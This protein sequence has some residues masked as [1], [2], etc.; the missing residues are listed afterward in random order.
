M[1]NKNVDN[2]GQHGFGI[3]YNIAEDLK[4]P[5]FRILTQL[6]VKNHQDYHNHAQIIADSALKMLDSYLI[7]TQVYI[8]QQQFVIEPVSAHAIIYESGQQLSKLAR[9]HNFEIELDIQRSIGQVMANYHALQS[10]IISVAYSFLYNYNYVHGK[11]KNTLLFSLRSKKQGA[12]IGIF[13]SDNHISA[14]S[15][16]RMRRLRG[17]ARTPL[18]EFSHGS[19]GGL[20]IADDLFYGMNTQMYAGKMNNLRGIKAVLLP[21]KQ[22][23]LL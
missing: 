8:G 10:A 7:S 16:Q 9:M 22:L 20:M 18:P 3:L 4:V 13:S 15:L 1:L 5:F 21:S 2:F 19:S 23:S 12:E 6:S 14:D 17:L 11:N